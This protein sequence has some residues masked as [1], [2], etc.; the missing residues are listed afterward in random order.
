MFWRVLSNIPRKRNPRRQIRRLFPE[1]LEERTL[2]TATPTGS[3]LDLGSGIVASFNDN[4][5]IAAARLT[6]S[7]NGISVFQ[8]LG[9]ELGGGNGTHEIFL[10][11]LDANGQPVGDVLAVNTHSSG[12]QVAPES[13]TDENGNALVVWSGPGAGDRQGIFARRILANGT[14]AAAE[15]RVNQ[16]AL[17]LQYDPAVA[18]NA[19]GN[20]VVTWHGSGV[21]ESAGIFARRVDST[22]QPVGDDILVNSTV[23]GEQSHASIAIDDSGNFAVVW[24]SR[25]SGSEGRDIFL[26]RFSADGTRVGSEVRVNT[27]TAGSQH[28]AVVDRAGNGE[29]VVAWNSFAQDGEGWGIFAQRFDDQGNRVGTERRLNQTTAG[30]QMDVSLALAESG[31]FVAAWSHGIP[32]GHGWE[33]QAASFDADDAISG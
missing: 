28:H 21:G 14:P 26:Q 16:S 15:C 30:H 12:D 20:S 5:V 17:G 3:V 24:T 4:A 2:F 31:E 10:K 25:G 6:S 9:T 13:A 8:G 27:T 7:G 23:L 18:M 33:V 11:R 1:L 22:G 19:T 32:N 29:F